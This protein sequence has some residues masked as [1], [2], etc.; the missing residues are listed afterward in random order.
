MIQ[1]LR[2]SGTIPGVD[3]RALRSPVKSSSL[4]TISCSSLFCTGSPI[5]SILATSERSFSPRSSFSSRFFQFARHFPDF[6]GDVRS[7]RCHEVS[8]GFR[9]LGGTVPSPKR[10]LLR[11]RARPGQLGLVPSSTPTF[12]IFQGFSSDTSAVASRE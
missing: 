11:V 9:L 2:Q 6:E 4:K 8:S 12:D 5:R 10:L 3:L 1:P 7:G